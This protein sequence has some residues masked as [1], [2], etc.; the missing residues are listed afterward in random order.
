MNLFDLLI[1]QPIFNLL[2]TI[3]NFVGDFGVAIILFTI[4]VKI[5]MWPLIRGQLHQTKIMRDIQPELKKIKRNAK[6][7]KQLESMQMMELYKKNNIK[8]FRSILM[9][10][11]QIPIFI[12]LFNVINITVNHRDQVQHF[13]YSFVQN[14]DR[15]SEVI[16]KPDSFQ[17]KLFGVVDLSTKAMPIK[18]TSSAILFVMAAASAILQ[19]YMTKQQQP[20]NNKK[21]RLRDIMSEAANG[22]EAD[23][24]EINS[25][26]SKQ[27]SF[28]L[29][30][31]MFY[32]TI[33]FFGAITFYYF[34]NNLI[35]VIQQKIVLS[36]DSKE[37]EEIA[38]EPVKREK[39]AKKAQ[40]VKNTKS[41]TKSNSANKN[42]KNITRIKAVDKKR[43]GKK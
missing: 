17:P 10:A 27:M 16:E 22:K 3:Y 4:I 25:I 24:S 33:N 40:I 34:L 38:N 26:V 13:T 36:E 43:K 23:Q 42:A 5:L 1:T 19:W 11:I 37:L 30:L 15:V 21:R 9:L 12:T 31:M 32:A 2:M 8:P 41:G 20:K 18:D 35:Q 7:N 28:M 29:P 6:G 14:F 39:N